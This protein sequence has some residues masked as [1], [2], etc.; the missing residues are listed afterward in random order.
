MNEFGDLCDDGTFYICRLRMKAAS[1]YILMPLLLLSD[2]GKK[3]AFIGHR[4]VR[5]ANVVRERVSNA[6]NERI[7]DGCKTFL[8]GAHGEYDQLA[9]D[10]CR[11]AKRKYPD[12]KIIV[13]LTSYHLLAQKNACGFDSYSDVE[14]LFY[15]IEDKHFKQRIIASNR[16]M[17]DE[18]DALICYVDKRRKGSG[19]KRA[20]SYA[21]KCGS[22]IVNTFRAE[23]DPTYYMTAEER[24]AYWQKR[25]K[26]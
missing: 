6:V 8:M 24:L 11:E 4:E 19:A 21:E 20:L 22:T 1:Y 18:C 3:T 9:L 10:V 14:T 13:V 25:F 17:I 12:I 23:D 7:E 16:C 15:E 26:K 2:M 5:F